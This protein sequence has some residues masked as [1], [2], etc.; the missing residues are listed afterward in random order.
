MA[1]TKQA[2]NNRGHSL[3]RQS[4]DDLGGNG[5]SGEIRTPGPLVPNQMRY[6]AA[7][8]S[9]DAFI[10]PLLRNFKHSSC[11]KYDL[12]YFSCEPAEFTAAATGR[13]SRVSD[14]SPR[15]AASPP[16]ISRTY[17]AAFCDL[18]A[19]RLKGSVLAIMPTSL[20]SLAKNSISRLMGVFFIQNDRGASLAN[21]NSIPVRAAKG[22][23]NIRP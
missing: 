21:M 4:I 15:R 11:A 17:C 23:L 16:P 1:A 14:P 20:P 5:R 3:A 2:T 12:F 13:C 6:Q 7:L 22:G 10:S 9:D 19:V 18:R 8:H